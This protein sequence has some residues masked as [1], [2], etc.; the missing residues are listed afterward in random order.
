VFVAAERVAGFLEW[1]AGL[2]ERYA[3]AVPG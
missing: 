2:P 3:D 1:A